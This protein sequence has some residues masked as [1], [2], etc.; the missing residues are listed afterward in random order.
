MARIWV[1]LA[2]SGLLLG[3]CATAT[4]GKPF[5]A[6]NVAQLRAGVSTVADARNLLGEPYQVMTN[7]A[8]ESWYTW[9][10]IRSD[11]S[12]GLVSTNVQTSQQLAVLVFGSDG[13]LLRA[14][15]LINVPAPITTNN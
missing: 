2:L 13:R 11:A 5:E 7:Q 9:Q 8:G 3:G 14:Q 6:G 10:Y 4:V 15:Q 12:S 1:V